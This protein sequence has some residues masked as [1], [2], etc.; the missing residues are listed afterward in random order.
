MS[1]MD[2]ILVVDDNP[3]SIWPLI[4]Q[5]ESD[6]E[7]IYANGARKALTLASSVN[8]PDLILLDVMMPEMDGYQ[9]FAKLQEETYTR[10]IPVIFITA[11]SE[12]QDEVK[13]LEIGAQDYIAK[14]F[15]LPVV[16]ARIK[17][18]LGLKKEL[19]RR[20]SL[21][22][23]LEEMNLQLERQ[24]RTNM[25]ELDDTREALLAYEEKYDYLFKA[26]QALPSSNT[27]L[28]VDDNPGNIHALMGALDGDYRVTYATT[29]QKA[30]E[31]ANSEDRPDAILLDVMMPEM[32]GYE[33][34]SR[35][36]ASAETWDIPIIFITARDQDVD[37]TKG[38]NLG[39]VD[40]IIKPFSLP[41]VKA[42]LKAALRLKEEM[43]NR[44][45]LTRK[46]ENLN[47]H[48][49]N[50]VKEKTVALQQAH[51]DLIAS[52][53]RYRSIYETAI[54]G[55][56]EVTPQGRL[57]SASPSLARILGYE[58]P[59]ELI[60]SIENV[61]EQLYV[62]PEDRDRFR[63]MLK[64]KG[65]IL[66]FE[67]RF[68]RK[69][70]DIIWVMICAKVVRNHRRRQSYYQGFLIDITEQ[71]KTRL[72]NQRQFRELRL[73]NKV[74][75]ASANETRIE[76]I[77]STACKELSLAF[78]LPQAVAVLID[79]EQY[80]A[81]V[82]AEH[83]AP[84]VASDA[85]PRCLL[86]QSVALDEQP[87][88]AALVTATSELVIHD[89]TSDHRIKAL[90][91]IL[92]ERGIASLL[93]MPLAIDDHSSGC[94]VIGSPKRDYFSTNKLRL[95]Q[96]VAD[97]I[98]G[99]LARIQLEE[100][101]RQLEQQYYQAQKMEAIGHLTGGVAHDFNNILTVILGLTDV[102]RIEADLQSD[103]CKKLDQIYSSAERAADLVRQLLAF[104]RQQILE[105]A[106]LNFNDIL[107]QF[108]DMMARIIGKGIEM[109]TQL[110]PDLDI[111]KADQGQME[112]VV[113]NLVVNA[114]DAM[115]QGGRLTIETANVVLD[116]TYTSQQVD[117]RPGPYVMLSV[118]DTGTGI[119]KELLPKVFIP[120]VTTKAKGEGTGL[121][122]ATV[123][124]IVKQSGG[125]IRVSSEP[126]Q[127]TCFKVYLPRYDKKEAKHT[128]KRQ[129]DTASGVIGGNESILVVEDDEALKEIVS[130]TLSGFGYTVWAADRASAAL[131]IFTAQGNAVDLLLTDVAIL[132]KENGVR[133]ARQMSKQ[134]PG[135]KVLYMSGYTSNT[136]VHQGI[137]DPGV[138]HIQKPFLQ[139]DL[140]RKV[141][142][143]LDET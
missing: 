65:E 23:R 67:T 87:S 30:L 77:L 10:D 125:H 26:A 60:T 117:V 114:Q 52:E 115:P 78:D 36:K 29:G 33:V 139:K 88:V 66:N 83:L 94:L 129:S 74:I 69:Q 17:S 110:D 62:Q 3:E 47:K 80:R 27:V 122:L 142:Q 13:G 106:P 98:C 8:R 28:V 140:A 127:G 14:P 90:R 19:E 141:R 89:V 54:E 49:E 73:L 100:Q 16:K 81:T 63:T 133:L 86:D 12:Y 44:I 135:L 121:G 25:M 6:Y 21:K 58:S 128:I 124:G 131:D 95:V 107:T 101:R 68:R 113:M 40:V 1:S 82:V 70:G 38:L 56:F 119:G 53:R 32:D 46:L 111:I 22:T 35:L 9:V 41:V 55:I 50:R 48:L 71:K 18:V 103:Q 75:A 91:G 84:D 130:D 109:V 42:R 57:L 92:E 37:E 118:S 136:I 20:L 120:F 112:Q 4:E 104:S 126:D 143:T 72:K 51:E 138:N 137:L 31:I 7:V 105:P 2:R 24:V 34:C 11:R 123:H 61:A 76:S 102:L 108:E 97:Q 15:S 79:A 43:D 96:R 134:H 59:L 132:G 116:E 93:L 64:Q 85:Q 39:A 45:V 5:L 99:V